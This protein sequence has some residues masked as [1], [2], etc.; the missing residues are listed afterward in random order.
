M[1]R[2]PVRSRPSSVCVRLEF[3]IGENGMAK[4]IRI[5]HSSGNRKFDT[6]AVRALARFKFKTTGHGASADARTL[7]LRGEVD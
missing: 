6:A 5:A 3:L 2:G 7:I 4:E 1:P